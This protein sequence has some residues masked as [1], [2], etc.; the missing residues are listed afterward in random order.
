M[1]GHGKDNAVNPYNPFLNMW[2]CVTRKTREG[3][4]LLSRGEDQP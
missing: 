1:I 3:R 4:D 2:M